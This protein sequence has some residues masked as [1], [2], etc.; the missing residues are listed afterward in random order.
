MQGLRG[1]AIALVVLVHHGLDRLPGGWLGVDVFFVISGYVIAR[2]LLAEVTA[3][4]T[5]SLV[6]FYARR[7]RR[8]VPTLAVVLAATFALLLVAWTP[9]RRYSL[10]WQ[11]QAS[12]IGV[13]NL[14]AV[15]NAFAY[16][17]PDAIDSPFSHMWSLGVE[18]QFYLVIAPLLLLV[19][20]ASRSRVGR[21]VA[22]VA[23]VG[24]VASLAASLVIRHGDPVAAFYLPQARAWELLVGVLLA[25]AA[26]PV[27]GVRR[28]LAP[29]GWLGLGGIL[30]AA[31]SV[32]APPGASLRGPLVAVA[33]TAM[34]IAAG[35]GTDRWS[36]GRLLAW[37]PLRWLG[38]I[39]YPLYLWHWVVVSMWVTAWP[40]VWPDVSPMALLPVGVALAWLTATLVERPIRW[41]PALVARPW[42]SIGG[43]IAVCVGLALLAAPLTAPRAAGIRPAG[44]DPAPDYLPT[45]LDPPIDVVATP[46]DEDLPSCTVLPFG[47][48]GI[49]GAGAAD[50]DRTVLAI[51]D[52]HMRA[53]L[54]GL[55]VAAKAEGW[56]LYY[57]FASGCGWLP[58]G[59]EDV[60]VGRDCDAA[61]EEQRAMAEEVAPDL[62]LATSYDDYRLAGV[63][64]SDYVAVVRS[65]VEGFPEGTRFLVLGDVPRAPADWLDC[66]LDDERDIRRCDFDRDAAF[67]PGI[68]A[69]VAEG[70]RAVG[71]D[72]AALA[73]LVC[74]EPTC[75]LVRGNVLVYR[76]DHHLSSAF[77]VRI[78]DALADLIAPSL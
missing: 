29:L 27:D 18:E 13:E 41:A 57:S 61:R 30:V 43:G 69:M 11:P 56:K 70:S 71:L 21:N 23:V 72:H 74:P 62:V 54:P 52:S 58:L 17:G 48:V 75:T 51:G 39:A 25:G 55:D 40:T 28:V 63:A 4:G 42:T 34:V 38:S 9:W 59:P 8:L 37:Q 5:V 16:G 64:T 76:D 60:V 53:L 10:G 1:V 31:V 20:R 67:D 19:A 50:G 66:L 68:A 2:S 15:R 45:D 26:L 73:P 44:S 14:W 7:V 33:G 49:C 77:T 3:E 65:T 47:E 36:V 32:A 24:I 22:L 12:A 46:G 78:A 35:P 6:G